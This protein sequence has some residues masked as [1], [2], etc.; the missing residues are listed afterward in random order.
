MHGRI[1]TKE[2]FSGTKEV[3]SLRLPTSAVPGG[4][5]ARGAGFQGKFTNI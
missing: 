5:G 3:S 1:W 2:I 4:K